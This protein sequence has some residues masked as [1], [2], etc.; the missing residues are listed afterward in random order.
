MKEY[1]K[2]SLLS[3]GEGSTGRG[4]LADDRD[5]LRRGNGGS[6]QGWVVSKLAKPSWPRGERPR[7]KVAAG[8]GDEGQRVAAGSVGVMN[9]R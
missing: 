8:N 2:P 1:R 4:K 6:T 7:S 5:R 3:E 9:R